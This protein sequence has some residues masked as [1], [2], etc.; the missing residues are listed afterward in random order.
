MDKDIYDTLII[1]DEGDYNGIFVDIG[2]KG[3]KIF[4]EKGNG[5]TGQKLGTTVDSEGTVFLILG[6]GNGD[7]QY[8][9]NGVK[10]SD[11][12][13]MISKGRNTTDIVLLGMNSGIQMFQD[14][15]A[16]N[17]GRVT[18][19]SYEVATKQ[20]VDEAIRQHEQTYHAGGA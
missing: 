6:E 5:E 16:L 9:F 1:P 8:T 18:V 19:N 14:N 2:H 15:L 7:N 13:L 20:Y 17:A 3:M 12:V 4:Q 11:D 10:Y